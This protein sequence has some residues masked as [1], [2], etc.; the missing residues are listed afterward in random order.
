[1]FRFKPVSKFAERYH[2]VVSCALNCE[3][4][5]LDHFCKFSKL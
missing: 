5:H 2:S 1:M 3:L 4:S